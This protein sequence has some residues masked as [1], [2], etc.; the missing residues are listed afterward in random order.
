MVRPQK[1]FQLPK[2]ISEEEVSAII[3]ATGNIKH[4]TMLSL[5]YSAGLRRGELLNMKLAN[6]D[7]KR[8]LI[9]VRQA[10]GSKDR[11]VSLSTYI[12]EML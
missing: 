8:M 2:V 11:V 10:K 4:R 5:M 1:P 3:S 9:W 6:I 12:L 7:S